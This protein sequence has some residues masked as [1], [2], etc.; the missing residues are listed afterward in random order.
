VLCL[1]K[2][3]VHLCLKDR[4]YI[5]AAWSAVESMQPL[6]QAM[7]HEK[8]MRQRSAAADKVSTECGNDELTNSCTKYLGTERLAEK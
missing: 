5:A 3:H 1:T 8:I 6:V 7:Q 4:I 2:Q